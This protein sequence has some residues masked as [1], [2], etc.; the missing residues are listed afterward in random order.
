MIAP[1]PDR[2]HDLAWVRD[3][4]DELDDA[5]VAMIRDRLALARAAA[6]TKRA[7]GRPQRDPRREAE[8]VRR[9]ADRAREL[10]VDDDSIRAVFRRLIDLSHRTVADG[11]SGR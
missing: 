10:G 3:R 7:T 4:I 9:A 5:L 6:D 2:P 1:H 11:G 8:V